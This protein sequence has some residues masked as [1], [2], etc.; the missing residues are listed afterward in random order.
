MKKLSLSLLVLL[1][2][3]LF[4]SL[5]FIDKYS[6]LCP[7]EYKRDM[8]IRNDRLGDG[9]FAAKR[10]GRRL[11]DGIDLYAQVGTPVYA[12]RS[13]LVI[14]AKAS[15][16]MGQYII[17]RHP[18]NIITIY[19]HLSEILVNKGEFVRQGR[20]IGLVGKTGNAGSPAILPHLHFEVRKNGVPQDPLDYLD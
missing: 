11:H 6:F 4:F 18:H 8:V 15:R 3:Y 2:V 7:I 10:N 9:Y 5:Y 14:A 20:V 13:G 16:G 19:G 12:S 1:P 17:I